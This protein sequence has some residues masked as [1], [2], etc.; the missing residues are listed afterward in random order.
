[1]CISYKSNSSPDYVPM[2]RFH[3]AAKSDTVVEANRGIL[4]VHHWG[5]IS[6]TWYTH[7]LRIHGIKQ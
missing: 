2:E 6:N 1:M 7:I 3:I 4:C 5:Q